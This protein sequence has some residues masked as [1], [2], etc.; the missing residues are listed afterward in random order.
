MKKILKRLVFFILLAIFLHAIN[1]ARKKLMD[2]KIGVTVSRGYA[3]YRLFPSISIC[4][5][6]KGVNREQAFQDIDTTLNETRDNVLIN[7]GDRVRF[8]YDR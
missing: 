3:E 1:N 2:G 7:I 6:R 4:F 8:L 5:V